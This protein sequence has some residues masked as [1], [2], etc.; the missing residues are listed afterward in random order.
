M[1]S[2]QELITLKMH[3][4]DIRM[5]AINA[6]YS[7]AAGHPGGS[8]SIADALAYLYFKHLNIRP[9]DPKWQGRDRVV[10]SK[11]HCS[12]ALYSALAYRGYFDV[13]EL[14]GFRKLGHFLQGHPSLKSVPG[15]DMST[16]SLGQGISAAC[17]IAIAAKMTGAPYRT[18]AIVGDGEMQEGEVW[19]AIMFAGD[20]KLDNLCMLVDYNKIQ[21]S[22]R[23]SEVLDIAPIGEKLRAFGWH[24]VEIDGHNMQAIDD[25]MTEAKATPGMPTAVVLN[26]IKGKGVSYMEDTHKWHG[27]APKEAQ[28]LQAME[29][30]SSVKKALEEQL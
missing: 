6:V 29:E 24:V 11:G 27:S 18:Y 13:E 14:K 5:G 21:I 3:A 19:E 23:V 12:P 20:K 4:T 25:A 10:L 7:A 16:G 28:Y 1:L 9:E 8:L 15:V 26:T 30:L 22:G 17:G 2:K